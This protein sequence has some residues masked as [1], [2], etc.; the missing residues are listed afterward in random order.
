MNAVGVA[1]GLLMCAVLVVAVQTRRLS[2]P[3]NA[4]DRTVM[5]GRRQPLPDA[6]GTVV[7]G[8]A[9]GRRLQAA[10]PR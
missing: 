3:P 5:C 4:N 7:R 6:N 2:P 8:L 10:A 1:S 9:P